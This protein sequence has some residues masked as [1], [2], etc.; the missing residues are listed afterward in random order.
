MSDAGSLPPAGWYPDPSGD[1]GQRWWD[2]ERWTDHVHRPVFEPPVSPSRPAER[3]SAA[4]E[5][6]AFAL[7]AA[8][9]WSRV[10]AT[11]ADGAIV[12]GIAVAAGSIVGALG[13]SRPESVRT[14]VYVWVAVALFY[15]PALLATNGGQT[16]G[17]QALHIRVVR[18]DGTPPDWGTALLRELVVKGVF[19]FLGLPLLVDVL[20]PLWDQRQRALHDVICSTRVVDTERLS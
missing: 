6:P 18:N 19:G 13:A 7:P 5:P 17:K 1:P 11:L 16:W 8:S 2:G 12:L 15:A 3:P 20:V 10:A 14:A 9:W 4:H